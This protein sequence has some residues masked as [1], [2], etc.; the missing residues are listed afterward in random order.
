[1]NVLIVDDEETIS[2]ALRRLA[3]DEGHTAVAAAS[4]EEAIDLARRRPFDLVL[5]DVR[6]PG[7]D[8]LSAM[9]EL[10]ALEPQAPI[11]VMTAFGNLATAV[12]AV[13]N[14]AFDYMTKPFDVEQAASVMRRALARRVAPVAAAPASAAVTEELVGTSPAMQ[15]VF[16]RIAL[17]ADTNASVLITGESGT[18]KEL[19]ARAIHRHSAC[20]SGPLVPVNLAALN[21]ALVESELFGHARGAF[22][23]ADQ[24]RQGLLELADGGTVFFDEAGEIPLPVQVKL[25]RALEQQEVTPVGDVRPRKA[26]FR[27]IAATHRDLRK[28]V[29]AGTFREDLFF[30]LAVFEIELPPLRQRVDDIAPLA[31]H[32]LRRLHANGQAAFAD[33]TIDELRRRPWPGNVRELR[34][35]VEHAAL[36]ARSGTIYPEHLPPI[37]PPTANCAVDVGTA[38][39]DAVRGWVAAR[40]ASADAPV[41]LYQQLLDTVEPPLFDAVL[42]RTGNNRLAAAQMLGMHRA[43]LRKKLG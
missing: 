17:V 14:G 4:A 5:L 16:K 25:L 19:V 23:G 26:A 42:E 12:E 22:T 15:E 33:A 18:G 28:E 36:L 39:G 3:V 43:T 6:L 27:V 9:R 20:A 35:A 24:A 32:F 21:P 11:V 41:E 1:M 10:Q 31:E 7:M 8:G 40:L 2:W 38:L 34:N 30:R 13:R 37:C 29:Q